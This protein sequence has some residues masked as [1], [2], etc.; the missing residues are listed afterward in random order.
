ML[1]RIRAELHL[2]HTDFRFP[3]FEHWYDVTCLPFTR[4]GIFLKGY[5]VLMIYPQSGREPRRKER[6]NN[7][8]KD[9]AI[10]CAVSFKIL[11][12]IPSGPVALCSF[13]K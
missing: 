8:H 11:L 2:R 12:G 1:L 6:L 5:C 10:C 9:G 4:E 3:L 13:N 7:K